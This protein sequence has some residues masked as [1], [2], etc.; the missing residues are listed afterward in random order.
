[1]KTNLLENAML[2]FDN[3]ITQLHRPYN[4]YPPYN[5]IKT[6]DGYTL[7]LAVAGWSKSDLKVELGQGELVISGTRTN[8]ESPNYLYQGLA[9][10]SWTRRFILDPMLIP[11]NTS[12]NNG[13]LTV[14]FTQDRATSTRTLEIT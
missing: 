10:R 3:L 4:G 14:S 8:E 13:V 11:K 7:E 9:H 5:V 2:G 6:E 12:L 1:M